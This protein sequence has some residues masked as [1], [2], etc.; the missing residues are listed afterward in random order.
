MKKKKYNN[1]TNSLS[2]TLFIT[3]LLLPIYSYWCTQQHRGMYGFFFPFYIHIIQHD[4]E[5]FLTYLKHTETN[6]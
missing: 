5:Q 6:V 3:I 1:I 2:L 4:F